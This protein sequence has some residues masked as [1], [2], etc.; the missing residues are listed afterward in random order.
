M[1]IVLDTNCLLMSLSPRSP[2]RGVWQAFLCGKYTLC[3]SNEIIEEYAEV[4]ARNISRNVSEAI[5]YAILTRSNV[6]RVDPHFS[7]GLISIDVDDNKFVDC[8]IVSNAR[9]IVTEDK[10]F[11]V[12]K[13]IPFPRIDVMGIDSFMN[14]LAKK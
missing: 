3:V 10:H 6:L 4:M 13:T 5:I 1:N 9:C 12:L 8:A 7:F 14:L 11:N 2:Y